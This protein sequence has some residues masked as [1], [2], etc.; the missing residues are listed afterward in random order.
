MLPLLVR[1]IGV[2]HSG[3]LPL[4]KEVIEILFS[5]GLLKVPYVFVCVLVG[6]VVCLIYVRL[7]MYVILYAL[8]VLSY[9][10]LDIINKK[11]LE[12]NILLSTQHTGVVCHRDVLNGV[13]HA[14]QDRTLHQCTQVRWH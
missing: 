8:F 13:E 5:A 7:C 4:T 1:G 2:H 10:I 3:L 6:I 11:I 9:Y 12:K 14:C